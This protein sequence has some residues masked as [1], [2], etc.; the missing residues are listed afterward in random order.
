MLLS[1]F[2]LLLKPQ[3]PKDALPEPGAIDISKLSRT[4]I[5]GYFLTVANVNFF[6][7]TISL[8]FTVRFSDDGLESPKSFEDFI[9]AIDITGKNIFDSKLIPEMVPANN[10]A[11]LTFTIPSNATSLLVLQPD[12]IT[13]PE[14]LN[15][16]NF[17]A[18][19]YVEIFLSSL[20]GSD[21][22]T[23]LVTPQLRGTFFNDLRAEDFPNIGLDQIAYDLP[24][25]NGGVFNLSN[26]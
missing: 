23:L 15:D 18:R 9:N 11:R 2:E 17:E 4:V 21:S 20:S 6:D 16:A 12:F 10:K 19:G 22:A 1:T 14:L 8:V 3:F 25:S 26:S 13:K 7:V 24:V 5:Q